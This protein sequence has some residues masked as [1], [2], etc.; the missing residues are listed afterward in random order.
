MRER[1]GLLNGYIEFVHPPPSGTLVRLHVPR[2]AAEP[3]A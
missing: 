2:E 1:A 3:D